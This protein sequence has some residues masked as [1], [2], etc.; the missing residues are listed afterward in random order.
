MAKYI[1][2][3]C[4]GSSCFARGNLQNLDYLENF[5]KNNN[6]DAEIELIGA[7]CQEKCESGPNI[8]VNDELYNEV[9]IKKLQEI[10]NN[11]VVK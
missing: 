9:D 11:L 5:I 4:M 1:I 3:V 8:Y 2:K 6:L 7:H 10:L